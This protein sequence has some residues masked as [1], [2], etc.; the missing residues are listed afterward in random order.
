MLRIKSDVFIYI[1]SGDIMI[2]A[3]SGKTNEELFSNKKI[4]FLESPC[5][6][7]DITEK[8]NILFIDDDILISDDGFFINQKEDD[9]LI[10]QISIDELLIMVDIKW[11]ILKK[12]YSKID[13]ICDF[14]NLNY[15]LL[16]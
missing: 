2:L 9:S 8:D 1:I 6:I 16:K 14:Y 11:I 3:V 7:K 4:I 13:E 12:I 15:L 10:N 5:N